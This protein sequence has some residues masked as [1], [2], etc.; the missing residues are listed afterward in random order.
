MINKLV[1][2][3]SHSPGRALFGAQL[4]R[5]SGHSGETQTLA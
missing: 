1:P 3:N 5:P 2:L 4:L